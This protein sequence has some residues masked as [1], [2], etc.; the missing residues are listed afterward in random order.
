LSWLLPLSAGMLMIADRGTKTWA[1][2]RSGSRRGIL[3]CMRRQFA[4]G[5]VASGDGMLVLLWCAALAAIVAATE[6]GQ[7][8]QVGAAQVGLGAAMGGSASNLYDRVW[9]RAVI[10]FLD[11][12]WWPIFNV[13]DVGIT[14]GAIAALWWR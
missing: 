7:I 6:S 3:R 2:R 14:L 4:P 12:R 13:A 10:D 11:L 8:F 1:G 9:R 5:G